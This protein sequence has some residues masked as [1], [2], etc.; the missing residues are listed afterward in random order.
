MPIRVMLV[1]DH[2]LF[3][4]GIEALLTSHDDFKV[5]GE[6][7]NGKE[8]VKE[9]RTCQPDI[10]LMDI[11]MPVCSGLD[12]VKMIQS[13]MSNIPIVMLTVSD[14]DRDLFKAIKNGAK[15]YLLKNLEPKELYEML[16][17]VMRGEA[18]L[19]GIMAAKILQELRSPHSTGG[20]ESGEMLTERE[21]DVLKLI[22][23]GMSNK[24]I[25]EQLCITENTVKVHVRTTLEKLQLRNRVQAAVY[26]VREGLLDPGKDEKI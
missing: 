1:D 22:A 21:R 8:A 2:I 16:L 14:D 13:E 10:I 4:K 11:D 23:E 7:S 24:E 6:A 18:P 17:G 20:G 26:A 25:A 5:V 15:G 12:A 9:A 3:R 19:T